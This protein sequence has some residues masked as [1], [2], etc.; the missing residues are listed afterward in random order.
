MEFMLFLLL[1]AAAGLLAGLFGVGGGLIIVPVLVFA[2]TAQGFDVELLTHMAVGTSLASIIFTSMSSAYAH[3]KKGVLNMAVVLPMAVGTIVGSALGAWTA[4]AI[5]G[6]MLQKIIGIF[7]LLM[8]VQIALDL[9]PKAS[10]GL[11]GTAGLGAAGGVIGWA[12]A[13]FGI[14]GGSL[15]VPFLLWR[16]QTMQQAVAV[17]AACGLPI[18]LAGAVSFAALGAKSSGL[19]DWSLG[20][21]YLPA[22]LGIAL[23][24]VPFAKVG[25]NLAHRLP[26]LLLKRLFALL[27]LSVGLKF[28]LP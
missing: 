16:G 6:P 28:L 5:S 19:P 26:Q 18:A 23:L 1:G 13:I 10:G 4:E 21:I 3:H 24:S 12:A 20:Y 2:F 11:P 9:R 25:A 15:S 22:L 14:G 27:L 8:A 17:S 7:A